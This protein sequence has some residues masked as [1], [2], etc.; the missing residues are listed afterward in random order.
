M[1][2]KNNFSFAS[3]V[4]FVN[5]NFT[6]LLLITA[7][8]IA[9]FSFGSMWKENKILGSKT[10]LKPVAAESDKPA[11]DT[12]ANDAANQQ[13]Q[14]KNTPQVTEEDFIRGPQDAAVTIIEYSDYLCPFCNKAHPTIE[15]I[16]EEYQGQV[17]WVYRHYPL[18]ALHP[19]A[20][21]VAQISECIGSYESQDMFWQFTDE[22]FTR[23]A[24][25]SS[26]GEME[27]V[28]SLV[29]EIGANRNQ[30]E[31]CVE[32]DEMTDKVAADLKG[33]QEA[34]V[35]GTPGFVLVSD[36]GE[37]DFLAGAAPY[38]NFANK[39]DALLN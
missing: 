34:G 9:G 32:S 28:Y 13:A 36:D 26:A 39:I 5:E 1:A 17:A 18:D 31:S 2:K 11:A 20:R 21:T 38:E 6:M 7:V 30:I 29:S 3:F 27:N 15:K 23:L 35:R 8:F 4:G 10:D 16:M 37:Y 33:G 14:L 25:D 22:L 19:D 24:E 12:N